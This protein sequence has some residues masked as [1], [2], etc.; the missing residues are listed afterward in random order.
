MERFLLS[1]KTLLEA[2]KL[3]EGAGQDEYVLFKSNSV[4][5]NGIEYAVTN[6]SACGKKKVVKQKISKVSL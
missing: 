5:E 6:I 1:K 3:T 2:L 4:V